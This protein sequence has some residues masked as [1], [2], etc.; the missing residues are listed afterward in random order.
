MTSDAKPIAVKPPE[1]LVFDNNLCTNWKLFKQKWANYAILT[2]LE[3]QDVKYQVALLLHTLGDAALQRYNGF[4]FSTE[5]DAR[6][7]KDI[8][9]KFEQY[10]VGEINET[11]ERFMF[12]NRKQQENETF[13]EFL[14]AIRVLIKTC[15]YCKDCIDSLL[16]DRI[17]LGLKDNQLQELLLR[18]RKLTLEK[19]IDTCRAAEYAQIKRK[20][21]RPEIVN[22]IHHNK[23]SFETK[24][25]EGKKEKSCKYCGKKHKFTKELC[26]AW[27]KTCSKCKKRN[28]FAN[29]CSSFKIKKEDSIHQLN[30]DEE[31]W[32]NKIGDLSKDIKC[33]MI[34]NGKEVNF[35][36][37]T[38]ATVNILPKQYATGIEP[39]KKVLKM[40]NG[41]TFEPIGLHREH[42]INPKN[43]KKYNIEFIIVDKEHFQPLLGLKAVQAMKLITV[44]EKEFQS[45]NLVGLTD[46]S[47]VFSEGIGEL[48][49]VVH[50]QTDH[51]IPPSTMPVHRVPIALRDKLKEELDR[52]ENK[53]VIRKVTEPTL[54][55]SNIVCVE[56]PNGKL[57]LCLNPLELNKALKRPR[58]IMPNLEE[59]L[60][61]LNG[62][63]VFSKFD[64]QNGYW[65]I[66]LDKESSLL[67]TFQTNF[68]RY[69][70][71]R[72]PFGLNVASEIFQLKMKQSF[73]ALPGL[74]NV[75][76]DVVIFGKDIKEHDENVKIFLQKCKD[77]KVKLNKEKMELQCQE[78]TFMGHKISKDGV[79]PDFKKIQ[80]IVDLKEP[81]NKEELKRFLGMCNYQMKFVKDYATISEPLYALLK[82]DVPWNWT[83]RQD[84]ALKEL[85]NLLTKAPTLKI[86]DST[87]PVQIECD[88]SK[89]GLGAVLMQGSSAIAYASRTLN[90]AERNY[91]QIEKEML[92]VIW[93][94]EKFHH[95]VYGRKIT[96]YNDHKPLEAIR[97]KPLHKAPKRL[98]S[99]L[100]R[101]Q[102]YNFDLIYK[103]GTKI[104]VADTL[105]RAPLETT[106]HDNKEINIVCGIHTLPIKGTCL[107]KIQ[108]AST[109]DEEILAL[110]QM[111]TKGWPEDRVDVSPI[112]RSYFDY[113]DELGIQD[114]VVVRGERIVIPKVMRK[115]M[116]DKIH[117]GHLGINSCLRRAREL[118]FWPGMST[119][120]RQ[121]IS[122]CHTCLSYSDRRPQEAI[123]WHEVAERPWQK[124]GIDL[125]V[126][127][128]RNYLVTVDY[129][130]QFI[131][132]D[133]LPDTKS[134]TVIGKVKHHFARYG[135]PE[136]VVTGGD[137]Q[138]RSD[139]FNKFCEAW[140]IKHKQTSPY[141]SKSNGQVESAVK[142]IKKIMKKSLFAK[143][144]PYLGLLNYRNTTLENVGKSPAQLLLGK[145]TRTLVPTSSSLF[146]PSFNSYSEITQ[147]KEDVRQKKSECD[148]KKIALPEY[149][150]GD[151]IYMQPHKKNE[152]W[153]KAVVTKTLTPR[154]FEVTT[155]NGQTYV[156]NRMFLRG[157]PHQQNITTHIPD[158]STP[159]KTI[160][161]QTDEVVPT[162][163]PDA[164]V[165]QKNPSVPQEV[166]TD[167]MQDRHQY[168]TKSGRVVKVPSR[169]RD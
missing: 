88:S 83:A 55:T 137:T 116:K 34:I 95:Y 135:A 130:S 15:S 50:L 56:K 147:R 124:V 108:D 86:F 91:A 14:S 40:W 66:S 112:I 128:G 90:A 62:A 11:Y 49:G 129:F 125:F 4:S 80:A 84:A 134:A 9:D 97:K 105:S 161:R 76:D 164:K 24:K 145:R 127:E 152:T 17:I 166:D 21:F 140:D 12:N 22:K 136:T 89:F 103:P 63:T 100:L 30:S 77:L 26:P 99:M 142:I 52:L 75:A 131:E 102:R 44:Q 68:G 143:E 123:K 47:D 48:P 74:I 92:A 67:T 96:V 72:L 111:I 54:W 2:N 126:L 78:I 38:G 57:R 3:K 60:H 19:C 115:E 157:T 69:C 10:V 165:N 98:Q 13:D 156:R 20:E 158:V 32:V 94:L 162:P 41:S 51:D 64:L 117:L 151:V 79:K 1:P 87:K 36:L 81:S 155:D 61:E 16:R 42:V 82:N 141:N 153:K 6:T 59:V 101:A 73:E 167:V 133:Y 163:N 160:Q 149:K 7:T 28:H 25:E 168:T 58:Y 53:G 5:E 46:Y 104:P 23:K 93:S 39:C 139:E 33:V 120:I 70:F 169:Y 35:Q 138:L 113:R 37:D 71:L 122:G 27:G 106:E 121:F 85:K 43:N 18:E 114:G 154:R 146:K 159:T 132:V 110:K 45:V 8:I 118:I 31:E 107:E 65:H 109:K 119:E 148:H 144:D 29:K 150:K